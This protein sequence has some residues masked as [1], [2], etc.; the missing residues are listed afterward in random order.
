MMEKRNYELIYGINPV[1]SVLTVNSGRRKVYKIILSKSR[2]KTPKV[3]E[4]ICRAMDNQKLQC[5]WI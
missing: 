2:K 4:I 5:I 3:K 1:Y